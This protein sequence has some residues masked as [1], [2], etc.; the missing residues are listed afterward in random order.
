[1]AIHALPFY[2]SSMGKLLEGSGM[3]LAASVGELHGYV[4]L[5]DENMSN[6]LDVAR[7]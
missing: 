4:R 3:L 7:R 2:T 5:E 6:M 1:M